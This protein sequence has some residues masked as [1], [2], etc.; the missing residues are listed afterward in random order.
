MLQPWEVVG[1]GDLKGPETL[2][3]NLR[4]RLIYTGCEDGWIKRVTVN[5]SAEDS[6]VRN[7]VNTGGR[8]LGIG[9]GHHNEV[10]VADPEKVSFIRNSMHCFISI[11][12]I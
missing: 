9:F 4:S 8:P 12:M 2:A 3:Y 11:Q 5:E 7:W 1:A 6:V 10:I